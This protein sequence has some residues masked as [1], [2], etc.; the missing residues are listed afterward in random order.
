MTLAHIRLPTICLSHAL[1]VNQRLLY[2]R[3]CGASLA[4]LAGKRDANSRQPQERW[5]R[6][7]AVIPDWGRQ[8]VQCQLCW[9]LSQKK[10]HTSGRCTNAEQGK[11]GCLHSPYGLRFLCS[12][13][14]SLLNLVLHWG[15]TWQ[16]FWA[17]SI[18]S[19][20]YPSYSCN[21]TAKAI[22]V[23]QYWFKPVQIRCGFILLALGN[24]QSPREGGQ[25]NASPS[26]PLCFYK[27]HFMKTSDL[28][29][30]R[31]NARDHTGVCI[32]S[33]EIHCSLIFFC[34]RSQIGCWKVA[35]I[36]VGMLVL[37]LKR[38][39]RHIDMVFKAAGLFKKSFNVL[40]YENIWIFLIL[41]ST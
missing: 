29:C 15:S 17:L 27:G 14:Q 39:H 23:A 26:G 22:L 6:S 4:Q 38:R 28:T 16:M 34:P 21:C 40:C 1:L 30:L 12:S 33:D 11:P 19:L 37:R 8:C 20:F 25:I 24:L 10:A 18:N 5:Q 2:L 13:A 41:R 32:S 36:S 7:L 3:A 9:G 31:N 35:T